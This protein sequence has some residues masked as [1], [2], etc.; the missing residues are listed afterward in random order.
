MEDVITRE[1]V[2]QAPKEAVYDAIANSEQVVRWFPDAIEGTYALGERPI[3]IFTG[4]GRAQIYIVEAKPYEYF[5]YRWIPGGSDFVGDVTTVPNTL[6]EFRI[7]EG[8]DGRSTVTM[9]E[10]GFAGLPEEMAKKTFGEN[11][12]GWDFMLGRLGKLFT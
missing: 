4:H 9:T 7:K 11:A 10:S 6:V 2:I 1:V 8:K 3:L 12:G 5:A